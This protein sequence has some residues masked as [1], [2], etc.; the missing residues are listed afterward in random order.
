[1]SYSVSNTLVDTPKDAARVHI[2]NWIRDGLQ[3][4]EKLS[5]IPVEQIY[6]DCGGLLYGEQSEAGTVDMPY[7]EIVGTRDEH[8]ARKRIALDIE[9]FREAYEAII[10]EPEE[11]TYEMDR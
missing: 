10:E 1:M 11:N 4:G 5:D 2:Y 7:A 3:P 8:G 9:D 6:Q